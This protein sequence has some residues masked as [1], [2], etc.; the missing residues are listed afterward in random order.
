MYKYNSS[1]NL[2]KL[3]TNLQ[4]SLEPYYGLHIQHVCRL[5]TT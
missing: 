5:C 4:V 1:V 2:Q 3:I